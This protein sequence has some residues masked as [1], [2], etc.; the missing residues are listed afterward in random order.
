MRMVGE[1]S[2]R[3]DIKVQIR[4]IADRSCTPLKILDVVMFAISLCTPPSSTYLDK[5]CLVV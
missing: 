5:S 1:G 3:S 4:D 2:K